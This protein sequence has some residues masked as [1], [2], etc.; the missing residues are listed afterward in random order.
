MLNGVLT[1]LCALRALRVWRA[2]VRGVLYVLGVLWRA[3]ACFMN[4]ACL[5][6]RHAI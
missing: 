5:R 1:W 3:L 6:A 4:L 2:R